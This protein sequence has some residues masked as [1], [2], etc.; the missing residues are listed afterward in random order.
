MHFATETDI[1]SAP[2]SRDLTGPSRFLRSCSNADDV[3]PQISD[4]GDERDRWSL[5]VIVCWLNW[6]TDTRE[7]RAWVNYGI[8][9]SIR[10]RTMDSD[11][12]S[13]AELSG[14]L[15]WLTRNALC[16]SRSQFKP[17]WFHWWPVS[18]D[19]GD[20]CWQH[21][22]GPPGAD[23]GEVGAVRRVYL[24]LISINDTIN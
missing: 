2:A 4:S 13:R 7:R 15:A 6:D 24:I 18:L 16:V 10:W 1:S 8:M 14:H 23:M 17:N 5:I 9:G 20:H 12:L 22:P 11:N 19:T 3:T 21:W